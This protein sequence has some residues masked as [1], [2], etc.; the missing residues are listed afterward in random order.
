MIRCIT[1]LCLIFVIQTC[2]SSHEI[3]LSFLHLNKKE[4]IL[5]GFWNVS[6]RDLE[7]S[8]GLDAN[9]DGDISWSEI[10]SQQNSIE[11]L[12]NRSLFFRQEMNLCKIQIDDLL[13][14]ELSSGPYIHI[15]ISIECNYI[16]KNIK[17]RYE[18]LFDLDAQHKAIFTINSKAITNVIS[19]TKKNNTHQI[20]DKATSLTSLF[21][22]YVKEGYFHIITGYDHLLFL[23]TLLLPC[24]VTVTHLKKNHSKNLIEVLWG[25]FKIVSI[26]TIAHSVSLAFTSFKI[27]SL[28]SWVVESII[29]FSI[30]LMAIN[31]IVPLFNDRLLFLIFAFG[32]IHGMGFA[33]IILDLQ[34]PSD[35]LLVILLAFN[36]GV[37]LG[38]LLFIALIL[39]ILYFFRT[40]TFYKKYCLSF[41]S[42]TILIIS[43]IWLFE[44]LLGK[45]F[46]PKF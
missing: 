9:F 25:I 34:L 39:P 43:S 4:T 45:Q 8:I 42:L 36:F 7:L 6:V 14:E 22:I 20:R 23:L 19:F 30:V 10:L 5:Q 41:L 16:L 33:S 3:S 13:I 12:V 38:Q 40:S 37:E 15:P 18:F 11:K 32:L 21:V 1:N 31:N 29:A 44:R 46:I 35:Y 17:L 2:V 28:E 27:I 26:F 24:C